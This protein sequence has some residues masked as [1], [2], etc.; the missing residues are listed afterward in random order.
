MGGRGDSRAVGVGIGAVSERTNEI[1]RDHRGGSVSGESAGDDGE[2]DE[3]EHL[4][5]SRVPGDT[6]RVQRATKRNAITSEQLPARYIC[7][8]RP[9]PAVGAQRI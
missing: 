3:L 6:D 4:H 8:F 2:A 1:K 9:G 7:V 5:A